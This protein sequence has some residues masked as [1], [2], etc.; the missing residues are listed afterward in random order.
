MPEKKG[1][2]I[3]VNLVE[4]E[5]QTEATAMVTIG[6]AQHTG[7]GLAKRNPSDPN[8]PMIGEELATARALMDLSHKLVEAAA[9]ALEDH[10]GHPVTL[11]E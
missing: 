8:V 9:T 6:D 2:S 11:A 4:D 10:I 7:S 1:L 3:E 5:S